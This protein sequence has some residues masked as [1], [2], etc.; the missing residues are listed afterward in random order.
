[1][2]PRRGD[3]VRAFLRTFAVQATWNYRTYVAGGLAFAMLPLLRRI[4]AGDPVSLRRSLERQLDSFNTHPYLSPL[5][6]AALARMEFDGASPDRLERFRRALETPLGAVGDR[7]V[8]GGWRP[9]CLLVA[10]SAFTLDA[11]A[12]TSAIL[13]LLL[14]NAGQLLLRAR[15]FRRG[16][17]EG[18]GAV[19]AL[20][21]PGL[22]RG[23]RILGSADLVLL[24][25]VAVLVAVSL[26]DA[27]SAA[28]LVG[29]AATVAVLAGYHWP[30]RVGRLSAA[31]L[32]A[33]PFF[34]IILG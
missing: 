22:R 14:Y 13:F 1:M 25:V 11:G 19:E 6:V 20:T 16:W 5:A 18:A 29:G 10:L 21:S 31:A 23:I 7:L 2:K 8:W 17:R 4:H 15:A 28:P 3:F 30:S 32:L 9:F 24:G 33:A 26:P 34:W 12:W 27:E